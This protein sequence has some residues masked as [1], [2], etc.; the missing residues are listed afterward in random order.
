MKNNKK[1][2]FIILFL[3]LTIKNNSQS[4]AI[5][6][7]E[8][9]QMSFG[10]FVTGLFSGTVSTNG[11]GTG[12]VTAIQNINNIDNAQ[13]SSLDIT[14]DPNEDFRLTINNDNSTINLT[15]ADTIT[16]MILTF[17]GSTVRELVISRTGL[18]IETIDGTLSVD[19]N[20]K[21]GLYSGS[22]AIGVVYI[23]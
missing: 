7:T 11:I 18:R 3:F 10:A 13:A 22:Y 6:I 1:I 8:T 15:H 9:D 16:T 12:G 20:Q 19:S 5:A 17:T 23:N 14:G 2:I 4:Q 21:S